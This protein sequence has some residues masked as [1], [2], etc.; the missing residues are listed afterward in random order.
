MEMSNMLLQTGRHKIFVVKW[1]RTWL[2]RVHVLV[3]CGRQDLWA[4]NWMFS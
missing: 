4:V 2:N 3:L 1:Q